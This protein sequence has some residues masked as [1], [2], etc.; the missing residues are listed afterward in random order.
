VINNYSRMGMA[1]LSLCLVLFIWQQVGMF[2]L[3]PVFPV[4]DSYI[5]L[6]NAN[7][8]LGA[9][10]SF[11]ATEKLSGAT[12]I[13]HTLLV[14]AF[15][16]I[17]QNDL[18]ALSLT[19]LLGAWL[20]L[21]GMTE[22]ARCYTDKLSTVITVC[23]AA[24][25]LGFSAHQL[26]N[27]LETS[28]AMAAVAWSLCLYSRNTERATLLL[29]LLL[30]AQP[31]IRP[32]LIAL[33]GLLIGLQAYR[34]YTL[35]HASD[36]LRSYAIKLAGLALLGALPFMLANILL[37]GAL[38]PTTISAKKFYFA[39]GCR[40]IGWKWQTMVHSFEW[41]LK[42]WWLVCLGIVG[43]ARNALG[44]VLL[45]FIVIF[46]AA[47]FINFTGALGHYE[48]RYQYLLLPIIIY[49]LMN[50]LL[51]LRAAGW[52]QA[53]IAGA[54]VIGLSVIIISFPAGVGQAKENREFT[55]QHLFP[56]AAW[57]NA[58]VAA[59]QVVLVHDA[60]YVG[61]AVEHKVLDD[62]VGLK[63]PANIKYHQQITAP[64]CGAERPL[65]IGAI[66]LETKPDVVVVY[67]VWDRIFRITPAYIAVGAELE[68]VL[69]TGGGGYRIYRVSYS[70]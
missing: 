41:L 65:A 24:A 19:A 31:F 2:S 67:D 9:E 4:D 39:E 50:A 48:G 23:F 61:Y 64:S 32:E 56:V 17:T 44:R 34:F 70:D 14:A 60:G 51:W 68:P 43:L 27:G 54:A 11:R 5:T 55:V 35:N 69:R 52:R 28:W 36:A 25:L 59:D 63:T 15:I 22:L 37:T 45:V 18:L 58:N 66:F 49:G 12:S 42:P 13:A 20:Y 26:S 33:S 40:D 46:Y 30:G 7:E 1:L 8:L 29:N 38:I 6:Q 10:A 47:Y 3:A 57:L 53:E 62:L 21:F 16:V